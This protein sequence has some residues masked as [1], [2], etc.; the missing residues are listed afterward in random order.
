MKF[1]IEVTQKNIVEKLVEIEC[2]DE[3]TALTMLNE[4][5]FK[6]L[7]MSPESK[8]EYDYKILG[9]AGQFDYNADEI[10]SKVGLKKVSKIVFNFTDSQSKL[11]HTGYC[12]VDYE[13]D[14]EDEN[15]LTRLIESIPDNELL[16]LDSIV[17]DYS[18][19]FIKND[20]ETD[21]VFINY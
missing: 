17:I 8:V 2:E 9:A 14:L 19:E 21:Q 10:L 11:K 3:K 6:I 15:L 13:S 5:Q 4:G 12:Y 20:I 18:V 16:E 7:S 1:K